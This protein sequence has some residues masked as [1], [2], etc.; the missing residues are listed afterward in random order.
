MVFMEVIHYF[1]FL[2]FATLHCHRYLTFGL[3][4]IL[5]IFYAAITIHD[6]SVS[7]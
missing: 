7:H 5:F 1:N 2:L 4:D 3:G 6:S